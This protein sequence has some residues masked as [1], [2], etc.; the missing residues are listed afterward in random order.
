MTKRTMR[1]NKKHVLR[2][3]GENEKE[4]KQKLM[5]GKNQKTI[6]NSR[7]VATTSVTMDICAHDEEPIAAA[8]WTIR[9]LLTPTVSENIASVAGTGVVI[10]R[11]EIV[12]SGSVDVRS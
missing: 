8:A 5:E 2:R 10:A 11:A 12:L 4:T 9:L 6:D 7:T 3:T 1:V